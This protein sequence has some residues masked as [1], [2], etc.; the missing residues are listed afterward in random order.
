[1]F[2][3][4]LRLREKLPESQLQIITLEDDTVSKHAILPSPIDWRIECP[5]LALFAGVLNN[6]TEP[7]SVCCDKHRTDHG[8]CLAESGHGQSAAS[9]PNA[10]FRAAKS[11]SQSSR[12][13]AQRLAN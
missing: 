7:R 6:F 4:P 5:G 13:A 11:P 2:R 3:C 12:S 8:K 9:D 10:I 1:M